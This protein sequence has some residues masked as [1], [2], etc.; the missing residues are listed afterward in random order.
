MSLD[1]HLK[2]NVKDDE[3]K[4][5]NEDELNHLQ[6]DYELYKFHGGEQRFME[7]VKVLP[8]GWRKIAN[9]HNYDWEEANEQ[10]YWAN[11]TH[12]LGEMAGAAGIYKHL[13][14]PEEIDITTA[15]QLIEPLTIGLVKLKAK[16]KFFEKFNSPNGWGMYEHFVPFVEEYLAACKKYPDAIIEVDR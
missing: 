13:W 9:Q 11:I 6:G 4:S 1:V 16:P 12:N 2:R 10:V 8:N 15:S 3:S 7:W 14:R 5:Y